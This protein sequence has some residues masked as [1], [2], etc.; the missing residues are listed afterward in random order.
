MDVISH[1]GNQ[2]FNR[3]TGDTQAELN[4]ATTPEAFFIAHDPSLIVFIRDKK[5]RVIAYVLHLPDGQVIRARKL[6]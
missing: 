5:G 1:R 2:L 3:A 6:R 4:L